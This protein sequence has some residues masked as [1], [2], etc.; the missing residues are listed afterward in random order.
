MTLSSWD[1]KGE[2]FT[3]VNDYLDSRDKI[4]VVC[5]LVY[6]DSMSRKIFFE[7]FNLLKSAIKSDNKK[8]DIF[9]NYDPDDES[10]FE[11]GK[12]MDELVIQP[13]NFVEVPD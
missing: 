11:L 5:S 3:Q 4:T 12:V 13:I 6:V 2:I 7:I 8:I 1:K 10:I 9:W